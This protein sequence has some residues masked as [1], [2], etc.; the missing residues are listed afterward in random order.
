MMEDRHLMHN[1]KEQ[2][3]GTQIRG[4]KDKNGNWIHFVWPI[5]NPDS[6]NILRER[7][8]LGSIE[9][10]AKGFEIEYKVFSLEEI[11]DL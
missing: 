10:Y 7:I 4:Q 1:S 6:V 9:E 2:I 11:N 5:K 8:G 3:Y